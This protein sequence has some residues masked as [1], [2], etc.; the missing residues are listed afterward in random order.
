MR[1]NAIAFPLSITGREVILDALPT[2]EAAVKTPD[3]FT[4]VP[5]YWVVVTIPDEKFAF[6]LIVNVP[7]VTDAPIDTSTGPTGSDASIELTKILELRAVISL[8]D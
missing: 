8:S 5:E 1:V 4:D 3:T 7:P 6:P 2:K